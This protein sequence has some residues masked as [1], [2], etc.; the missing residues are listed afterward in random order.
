MVG[1]LGQLATSRVL[2]VAAG[3]MHQVVVLEDGGIYSWG[4]GGNGRLGHGAEHQ[5]SAPVRL[6]QKS[7]I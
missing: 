5:Q 3:A 2:M 7:G 1:G 4:C 6:G